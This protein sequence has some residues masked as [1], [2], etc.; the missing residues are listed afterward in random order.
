MAARAGPKARAGPS[1]SG[2]NP[3][4]RIF[5]A[6]YRERPPCVSLATGARK[7]GGAQIAIEKSRK[8]SALSTPGTRCRS[9]ERRSL[10]MT[11]DAL[12][13]SNHAPRSRCSLRCLRRPGSPRVPRPFSP[14]GVSWP[15]GR[16]GPARRCLSEHRR[17]CGAKGFEPR[18]TQRDRRERLSG[19]GF[20]SRS[21]HSEAERSEASTT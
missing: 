5:R 18:R 11:K 1:G 15:A 6:L 16:N 19:I 7:C 8:P 9:R 14:P 21:A 10:V 3:G 17:K 20:K 2:S 12:R 13:L 4:R